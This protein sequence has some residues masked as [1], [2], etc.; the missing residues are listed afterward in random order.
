MSWVDPWPEEAAPTRP[1]PRLLVKDHARLLALLDA[2]DVGKLLPA[3]LG[4]LYGQRLLARDDRRRPGQLQR[5]QLAG[6]GRLRNSTAK[7]TATSTRPSSLEITGSFHS[8][9]TSSCTFSRDTAFM[10]AAESAL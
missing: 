3:R 10:Y 6:G 4:L 5:Q 2:L 8:A 7:R 9:L 1:Y